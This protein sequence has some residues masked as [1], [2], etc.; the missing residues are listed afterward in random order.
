M[1]VMY[2]A[3]VRGEEQYRLGDLVGRAEAPSGLRSSMRP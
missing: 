2:D 3:C 1:P